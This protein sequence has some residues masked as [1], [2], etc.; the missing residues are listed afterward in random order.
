MCTYSITLNDELLN[1]TRKS[2]ADERAMAV[3]L[4]QQVEALLTE[5]N[6]QQQITR[7]NARRAIEEMRR[8]SEQNGNNEMTLENINEEIRRA[9]EARKVAV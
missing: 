6:A 5:Y 7:D 4:Q 8:Q 3:W 9:R 2:F 1:R